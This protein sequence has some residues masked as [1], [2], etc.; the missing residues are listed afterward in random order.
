[1]VASLFALIGIVKYSDNCL[2][3][4]ITYILFKSKYH[5]FDEYVKK[6]IPIGNIFDSFPGY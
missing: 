2:D 5:Y 1:M 6:Q 4:Y 3:A